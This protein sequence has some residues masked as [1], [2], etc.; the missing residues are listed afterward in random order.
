MPTRQSKPA[1]LAVATA[2]L[3]LVA[4][5]IAGPMQQIPKEPIKWS[6]KASLPEK[7]LKPGDAFALQLIATIEDG[8][9]LYSTDQ[10]EGGPIPTRIVLPG[11]QPFEQAG[12]I[13]STEPKTEMDPNFNLMT[14]Y[15][16]EQAL[17]VIPVKV[18][19]NDVAGKAEARVN[20]SFQTCNDEL[21]LQ[22]RTMKL[23]LEI[24]LTR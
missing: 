12:N 19:A 1:A 16:E 9:H 13:E 5:G 22:P 10:V 14:Q 2:F 15:Y 11:G 20:V 18:A 7:P 8:W 23:A 21:C 4:V 24:N 3:A 17:F 6:I